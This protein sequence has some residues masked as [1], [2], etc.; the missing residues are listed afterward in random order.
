[1]SDGY[2]NGAFALGLIAGIGLTLNVVVWLD[3]KA[4]SDGNQ[5]PHAYG[6][7][8]RSEVGKIWDWLIGTFISPSDTLAQWIMAVFTIAAVLLVWRTLK[9]TQEMVS[10]TRVR[11]H[12]L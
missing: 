5:P 1:M 12:S 2:R 7:D 10:D 3:Y 6:D 11:G 8:S 4:N 9:A